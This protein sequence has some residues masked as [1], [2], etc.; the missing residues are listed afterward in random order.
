MALADAVRGFTAASILARG[1]ARGIDVLDL[2]VGGFWRSFQAV[3]WLVP[4][5]ALLLLVLT[6]SAEGDAV[7]I[8]WTAEYVSLFARFALFPLVALLL[9][10][11]MGLTARFVPL[12]TAA[13]WASVLQGGFLVTA[14]L[15]IS[16]LPPDSRPML[17]FFAFAAT[18]VYGWFVAR[19]ALQT[20]GAIA[21]GFVLAD[22]LSS[23]VLDQMLDRLFLA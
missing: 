14:L 13:N 6:R 18:M 8:D 2:S 11:L 16:L 7:A 22:F 21:F 10:R 23:L 4:L 19:S 5:H 12:V 15:L 3:L 9:T 20:S 17:Q 1:D